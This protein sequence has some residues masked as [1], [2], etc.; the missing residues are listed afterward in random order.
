MNIIG[1]LAKQNGRFKMI[2]IRL[3]QKEVAIGKHLDV[4]SIQQQG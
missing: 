4:K 1:R 2:G 3:S